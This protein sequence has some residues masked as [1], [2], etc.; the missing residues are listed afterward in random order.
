MVSQEPVLFDTTIAD[1]IRF[2]FQAATEDDI[3]RAAQKA[4]AHEFISR[5][6]LGYNTLVGESQCKDNGST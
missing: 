5:L 1:N 4:N 2:G 6:P 3:E